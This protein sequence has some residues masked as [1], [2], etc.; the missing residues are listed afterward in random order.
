MFAGYA[1]AGADRRG[2]RPGRLVPHRRPG[3][4]RRRRLGAHRRA[5]SRTSSSAAAR[6]SRPPRSRRRS[7]PTPTSATRWRWGIP[8]RS[9]AS[10]SPPS[11][12]PPRPFDLE[13][14]RRWFAGRGM[15]VFKTPEKVERL[16]QPA[17]AR[18]GQGRPGRVAAPRRRDLTPRR[19]AGCRRAGRTS[20][21]A[22]LAATSFR[23]CCSPSSPLG[24]LAFAVLGAS[25]APSGATLTVQNASVRTFGSPT[26]STSSPWTWSTRLGRRIRTG[27]SAR[28]ARSTTAPPDR[29][30]VYQVA[31][32]TLE[33]HRGPRARRPSRAASA[34]TRPSSAAPHRGRPTGRPTRGPRAWRTTTPGCRTRRRPRAS[35]S[36]RPCRARSRS[37]RPSGPATSSACASPSSCRP[38]R[39]R[40]GSGRRSG[41]ENQSA[42][43]AP[44]QRHPH[45]RPGLV[46]DARPRQDR[47]WPASRRARSSVA[48]RSRC[49][50]ASP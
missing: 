26:G 39:C 19:D 17:V 35:R 11:S 10:G 12:S 2:H 25:S 36:R 32:S 46:A 21:G 27:R 30:T 43:H 20:V 23:W 34:R 31:G 16:E 28:C 14:C 6:T 7:R 47:G 22:C 5:G 38:R 49:A 48:M 40:T 37:G 50:A 29:M 1:D 42:G 13:E 15:A 44:D 24:T 4:G 8:T 41:V 18:L 45:R 9:W 3:H 33:A